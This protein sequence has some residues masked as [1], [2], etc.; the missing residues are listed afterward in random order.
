MVVVETFK[1][2]SITEH[3]V[4]IVERKGTGHPDQICDSVMEAISI[5]L[6][7]EYL[8]RFGTILH[9]NIDKGLLAAGR[10]EKRFGGGRVVRPMELIIGDRATFKADG[11]EIPVGDI[12]VTAAKGWIRRNLRFVDP[13]RHIRYRVA[14]APGSDELADIFA[15]PGEVRVA[16]DT[17]AAVGYY[18]LSPTEQAVLDLEGFLLAQEEKLFGSHIARANLVGCQQL[19]PALGIAQAIRLHYLAMH[20]AR[21]TGAPGKIILN[22]VECIDQWDF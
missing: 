13:E 18:P 2:K 22:R 20:K 15:R 12:A 7:R 16:N 10:V 17:S 5:A 9:H 1:G 4:E 19:A 3:R 21:C 14:L 11:Q 8:D 6:C